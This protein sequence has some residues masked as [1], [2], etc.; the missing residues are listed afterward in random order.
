[1]ATP[2]FS[3]SRSLEGFRKGIIGGDVLLLVKWHGRDVGVGE[4][5]VL[6]VDDAWEDDGFRRGITGGSSLED[7]PVSLALMVFVSWNTAPARKL[8]M[9]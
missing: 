6:V 2:F 9:P 1:M 7:R 3:A 5:A 8:S 4:E